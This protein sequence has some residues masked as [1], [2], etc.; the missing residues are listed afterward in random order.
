LDR[1]SFPLKAPTGFFFKLKLE[2]C[3]SLTDLISDWDLT[4]SLGLLS[5]SSFTGAIVSRCG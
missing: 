1:F 2:D 5:L 4:V 3:E